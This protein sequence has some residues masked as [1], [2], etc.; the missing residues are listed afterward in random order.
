MRHADPKGSIY[1]QPYSSDIPTVHRILLSFI[2]WPLVPF[3]FSSSS[4]IKISN[5]TCV[6]GATAFERNVNV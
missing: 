3:Q 4:T 2:Q 6:E 5:R 1:L